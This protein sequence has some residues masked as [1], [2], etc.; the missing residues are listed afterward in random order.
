MLRQDKWMSDAAMNSLAD[1][2]SGGNY[3]RRRDLRESSQCRIQILP[4]ACQNIMLKTIAI[5]FLFL[6]PVRKHPN[7]HV[8][9]MA[10]RKTACVA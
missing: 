8:S 2:N 6:F 7:V 10:A 1:Y 4:M 5:I 3:A 9:S